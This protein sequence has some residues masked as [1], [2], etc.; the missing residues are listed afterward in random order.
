MM[1]MMMIIITIIT[2]LKSKLV[3]TVFF[4][5]FQQNQLISSDEKYGLYHSRFDAS[6]K[7]VVL[8]KQLFL[9]SIGIKLFT[10]IFSY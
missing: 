2:I 8:P 4:I 9:L 1:M 5:T 7:H 10:F 6:T 3:K